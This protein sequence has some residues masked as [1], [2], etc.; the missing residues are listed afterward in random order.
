MKTQ[1]IGFGKLNKLD[2]RLLRVFTAIVENGGFSQAQEKLDMSASAISTSM[3]DLE[4]RFGVVLCRRGRGGF[5]LTEKGEVVYQEARKLFASIGQ[6]EDAIALVRGQL[7]GE[8]RLGIMDNS[9]L[10]PNRQLPKSIHDFGI[11]F[12]EAHISIE[13]LPP[14]EIETAMLEG[15]VDVGVGAFQ[16]HSKRLMCVSEFTDELELYCGHEHPLFSSA[17]NRVRAEQVSTAAYAEGVYLS[18]KEFLAKR[19]QQTIGQLA[20]PTATARQAEGL[21]YLILSGRYIGYLPKRYAET[22]VARGLMLP[23]L[24][25]QYTQLAVFKVLVRED[26]ARSELLDA[27]V[28]EI[29]AD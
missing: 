23:L 7:S 8:L 27:F 21:G 29:T 2:V 26:G 10:D 15:R 16:T 17:P 1:R 28:S 14:E 11:R 13:V 25:Q 24:P 9:V 19:N 18:E 22:W 3:T 5:R 4:A 20:A 12:P 6:F